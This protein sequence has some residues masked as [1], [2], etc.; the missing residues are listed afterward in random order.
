M[1]KKRFLLMG[2]IHRITQKKVQHYLR[3]WTMKDPL[4]G[5]HLFGADV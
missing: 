4:P 5:N 3:L 2:T 1:E